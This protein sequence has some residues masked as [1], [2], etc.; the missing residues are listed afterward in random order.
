[1]SISLA[2]VILVC[3]ACFLAGVMN[4]SGGS[5]G[6][7]TIPALMFAGLDSHFAIGTNKLQAIMGLGLAVVR[8][9]K[10]G[11]INGKLALPCVVF[12]VSGAVL[13]SNLSLLASNTFLFYLM[14][15]LLPLCAWAVLSNK[16]ISP[17]RSEE[18]VITRKLLLTISAIALVCGFY[19][20][21][22]GPGSGTFL[23]VA[24]G[25]FTPLGVKTA[26]AHAKVINLCDNLAA[27]IVFLINGKVVVWLGLLGGA[28]AMLGAWVGAGATMHNGAKFMKPL[29]LLA[30]LLLVINLVV[31]L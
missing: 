29:L 26:A 21:F 25:M 24:L 11:F 28:C 22:Y 12:G 14:F 7:I 30:L 4:A 20:G 23:V 5:G 9:I 10:G 17:D 8:Y 6:L 31:E 27:V 19:D 15:A 1:M 13:G 3:V 16:G 2:L 18:L